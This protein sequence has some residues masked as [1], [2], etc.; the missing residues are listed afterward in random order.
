MTGDDGLQ[1]PSYSVL[2]GGAV[3]EGT[4]R[5]GKRLGRFTEAEA[6]AAVAGIARHYERERKPGEE[7]P[8]PIAA[9]STG[10]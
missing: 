10:H 3:G 9:R 8:G 6:P 2:V 5:V 4:A 7:G 1:R